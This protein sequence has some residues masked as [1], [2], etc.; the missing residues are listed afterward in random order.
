M[1]T[2]FAKWV[3]HSIAH[4]ALFK[5]IIVL[6]QAKTCVEIGVAHGT[7]SKWIAEGA[8]AVGGHLYG[9]D[10]WATH[11]LKVTNPTYCAQWQAQHGGLRLRNRK[12][13]GQIS[14]R[15]AVENYLHA[16]GLTAFT[17]TQIDSSCTNFAALVKSLCP[18]IDFAFIDGDH[19]Y[20]GLL[21][22][23]IAVYPLLSQTGII[24]FHDT[25]RIDGCREFMLDLRTKLFDGT[26]DIVDFPFGNG[27]R[28][29]GVSL[30]V[31]RAYPVIAQ[32]ID[33]MCGSI[34]LP[35]EIIEKE[36]YW[37][38]TQLKRHSKK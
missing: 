7:T 14:S 34:S 23:F 17:M 36:Q 9:F 10:I 1:T 3:H 28:R 29:V 16:A 11:G 37:Y 13:F 6:N 19:S 21:N 12:A 18:V 30:L 20:I 33:E 38:A 25:L 35:H 32:D 26:Y 27:A 4:G 8:E 31:K 2:K 22:D 5:S 24:A 15:E